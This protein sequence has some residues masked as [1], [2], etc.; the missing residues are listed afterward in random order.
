MKTS[1]PSSDESKEDNIELE[2]KESMSSKSAVDRL[3]NIRGY[4][5]GHNNDCKHYLYAIEIEL[6][7]QF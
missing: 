3:K 5:K 1:S 2:N 7:N 6:V 4:F